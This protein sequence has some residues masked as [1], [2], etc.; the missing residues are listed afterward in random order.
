ME[1]THQWADDTS[2]IVTHEQTSVDPP[3]ELSNSDREW[4]ADIRHYTNTVPTHQDTIYNEGSDR[5][6]SVT[7][8]TSCDTTVEMDRSG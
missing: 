7:R 1:I 2:D 5:R 4:P 8:L 3:Q 6:P